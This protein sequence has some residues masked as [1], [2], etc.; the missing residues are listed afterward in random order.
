MIYAVTILALIWFY[1]VRYAVSVRHLER[2]C[3][4]RLRMPL[5]RRTLMMWQFGRHPLDPRD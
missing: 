3:R 4:A 5:T 1:A 2:V